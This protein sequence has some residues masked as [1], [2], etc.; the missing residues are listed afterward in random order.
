MNIYSLGKLSG[1]FFETS[2]SK[3]KQS[4]TFR[5]I[6][7]FQINSSIAPKGNNLP[8]QCVVVICNPFC[9]PP[10]FEHKDSLQI[11]YNFFFCNNRKKQEPKKMRQQNNDKE[12]ILNLSILQSSLLLR[13]LLKNHVDGCDIYVISA[14]SW[15]THSLYVEYIRREF[16]SYDH[17][18]KEDDDFMLDY[19]IIAY[20]VSKV[21]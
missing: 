17:R 10:L 1:K 12:S 18:D 15:L 5:Q 8:G 7:L 13:L 9:D 2:F 11:R 6:W 4:S 14:I 20:I 16:S 19:L 3:P 21:R